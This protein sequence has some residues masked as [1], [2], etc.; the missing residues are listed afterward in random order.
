VRPRGEA[1]PRVCLALSRP[2]RVLLTVRRGLDGLD[3]PVVA[4]T[5]LTPRRRV[6]TFALPPRLRRALREGRFTL[7]ADTGRSSRTTVFRR[8]R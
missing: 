7:T 4:A 8:A 5:M 2:G 6:A 3:G 1:T